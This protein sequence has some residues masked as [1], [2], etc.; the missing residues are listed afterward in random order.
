MKILLD[1]FI[2]RTGDSVINSDVDIAISYLS[3]KG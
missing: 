1:E 3:D 2:D